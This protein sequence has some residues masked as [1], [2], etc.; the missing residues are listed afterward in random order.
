MSCC[1]LCQG[2]L[3]N[4][5]IKP[6]S[7]I[8]LALAGGFFT[9]SLPGKPVN[10]SI[11]KLKQVNTHQTHMAAWWVEM[12]MDKPPSVINTDSWAPTPATNST[13]SGQDSKSAFKNHRQGTARDGQFK[14]TGWT[15]SRGLFSSVNHPHEANMRMKMS[16]QTCVSACV[17]MCPG[18][19]AF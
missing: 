1:F 17:S 19:C 16:A 8:S 15:S 13:R 4:P 14:G 5:G 10:S 2:N 6:M 7:P 12:A 18:L 3:P 9:T 11:N